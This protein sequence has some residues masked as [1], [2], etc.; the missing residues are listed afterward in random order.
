MQIRKDLK[1]YLATMLMDVPF[2]EKSTH[3]LL[4]LSERV[5]C[6]QFGLWMIG[7]DQRTLD[8]KDIL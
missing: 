7:S 6:G 2:L 5:L 4:L 8:V 3:I 1:S